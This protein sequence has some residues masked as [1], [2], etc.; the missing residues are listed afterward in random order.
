VGV[1][2]LEKKWGLFQIF[3]FGG[4]EMFVDMERTGEDRDAQNHLLREELT[5]S[6]WL[7]NDSWKYPESIFYQGWTTTTEYSE[8]DKKLIAMLF[9]K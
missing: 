3:N 1:N 9:R 5:Q 8:M 4:G 7:C 2:Q 6:L